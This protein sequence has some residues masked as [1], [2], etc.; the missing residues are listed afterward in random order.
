MHKKKK[1][2]NPWAWA[3]APLWLFII[4][5]LLMTSLRL[6][7]NSRAYFYRTYE[8][9]DIQ[10]QIGISAENSADAI[11]AMIDYM[12]GK[13]ESIQLTVREYG[14]TVEM[15]N[16]QEID[17]MKDVRA[18]YQA[19]IRLQYGGIGGFAALA[20][21]L[22][23]EARRKTDTAKFGL[24]GAVL[25]GWWRALAAFGVML[26]AIGTY[27]LVDFYDF[28]TR[29]HYIFFTNDLWLMDYDAC[30]MIRI[31][32]LGLFSGIIA[33]FTALALG[34]MALLSAW[35]VRIGRI[36]KRKTA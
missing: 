5:A 29:F 19:F 22:A 10:T 9:M 20:C 14:Q 26:V 8:R 32:P 13:R 35:A 2:T 11:M 36:E 31:C 17:H 3:V 12:E 28:W 1:Q 6:T 33:R 24:T 18:L 23:L 16:Q 7:I 21:L 4:L 34:G 15:F 25:G 27:A 30:R